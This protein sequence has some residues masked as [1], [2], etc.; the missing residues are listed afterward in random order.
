MQKHMSP[1]G[2]PGVLVVQGNDVEITNFQ[3]ARSDFIIHSFYFIFAF[4]QEAAQNAWAVTLCVFSRTESFLPLSLYAC[5]LV[6]RVV[7]GADLGLWP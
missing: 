6:H 7:F 3:Y 5:C 1:T 4:I 2:K